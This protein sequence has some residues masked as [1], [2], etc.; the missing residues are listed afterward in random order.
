MGAERMFMHLKGSGRGRLP[1]T[2]SQSHS[3]AG[4]EPEEAGPCPGSPGKTCSSFSFSSVDEASQ[5]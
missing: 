3:P 2:P 5:L 1:G 4:P